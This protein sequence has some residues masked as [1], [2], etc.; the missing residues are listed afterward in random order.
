MDS[1]KSWEC[2]EI[3]RNVEYHVSII[4]KGAQKRK[5]SLFNLDLYLVSHPSC[6]D[7]KRQAVRE[8][9]VVHDS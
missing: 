7:K 6:V 3:G 4:L 9:K 5:L 8:N 2:E 1:Q